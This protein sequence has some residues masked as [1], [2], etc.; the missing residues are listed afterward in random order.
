M[1]RTRWEAT[2]ILGLMLFIGACSTSKTKEENPADA[3]PTADAGTDAVPQP[4]ADSPLP[5]SPSM[6]DTN[7]Q[8]SAVGGSPDTYTVQQGDTLMKIAYETTGDIYKWR[9]IYE[10]NKDKINDPNRIPKGLV[11]KY[12]RPGALNIERNG[13]KYLIKQGDTLGTIS[14]TVYGTKTRWKE[15]WENNKQL[16]HD[17]NKI[18]AG[19]Y[20]YYLGSGSSTSG[21]NDAVPAGDPSSAGGSGG[22]GAKA[23]VA[24]PDAAASAAK[25]GDSA[26]P[27]APGDPNA[28]PSL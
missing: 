26:V 24:S 23:S 17:P 3:V 12:T 16:I 19:F 4:T 9:E 28:P 21:S 1:K 2:L 15:L 20:L 10:Q 22:K 13:E 5:A 14:N 8:P 7:P 11:L 25:G 6:P 18:F 27:P